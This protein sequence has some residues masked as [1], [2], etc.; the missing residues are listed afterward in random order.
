M[1][2]RG[3]RAESVIER[4]THLPILL[5]SSPEY[6]QDYGDESKKEISRNHT[7]ENVL[8][9]SNI[10]LAWKRVRSNKGAAG[11]D[12]MKI[13]DFPSFFQ[14]HWEKIASKLRE[15]T[16]K[17]SPVRQCQIPKANGDYRTLGIPT[18]L[19][20]VIQQAIAQVIGAYHER[21]FSDSSHG[22][23]PH[24]S[25]QGA[26][27]QL[28]EHAKV[29]GKKCTVVD[30]DLKQFFDTIDHQLMMQ[31]LRESIADEALLGLLRRFLKA[32]AITTKGE[33]I[34]SPK[35]M[36]QG[37]PLSPLL[38][39][40]LLDDLDN[41]LHRRGHDHVRYADDFIILCSSQRAGERILKSISYYLSS[42]LRLTVNTAKSK[43]V[44]LK[45]ASF[46]GFR[47]LRNRIK[48]TDKAKAN[49][50]H[51][52]RFL[53][54][55]S[56]GVSISQVYTEIRNFLRGYLN[57][58]MIGVT[59]A[60]VRELD[61]WLRR[62]MRLLYWKQWKRPR[63]RRRNLLKLGAPKDEVKKATRSR[64]GPWRICN[65]EVVRFAMPNAWLYE[66][67]LISLED[68]WVKARYENRESTKTT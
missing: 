53:M 9:R 66:Q 46:L 58:F 19:D 25:A 47:I 32:G 21:N 36:P 8:H 39:N 11:V 40:I 44:K 28:L 61:H 1:S 54:G 35:G 41:E 57:Y 34:P 14:D 4:Q 37:G 48:W 22:Y 18:V 56:R 15:G 30:C 59:F 20:R 63:T 65:I 51:E 45:E 67:G 2:K 10:D 3:Q 52:A 16:Y 50:K 33:R 13:G 62:R 24:R 5:Q 7:L 31:K 23:R 43:V 29:R 27:K 64:K 60:E 42:K 26:T 17:P 68:Q 55:R 12:G 38:A 6:L 49:L